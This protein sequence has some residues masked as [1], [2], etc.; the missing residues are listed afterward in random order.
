MHDSKTI[1]LC[2]SHA[3]FVQ[4]G[5]VETR[6]LAWCNAVGADGFASV[7]TAVQRPARALVKAAFSTVDASTLACTVLATTSCSAVIPGAEGGAAVPPARL[8]AVWPRTLL[9]AVVADTCNTTIFAS[10]FFRTAQA[11]TIN[12][13]VF[14]RA[15][16]R[17]LLAGTI[18]STEFAG[19]SFRTILA[20][21]PA[22]AA[23]VAI[24]EFG[25]QFVIET[26]GENIYM[27][28]KTCSGVHFAPPQR[29]R[30]F[31]GPR[32]VPRAC[33]GA[34]I[35]TA[36]DPAGLASACFSAIVTAA[37]VSA[38]KPRAG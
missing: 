14:A 27:E 8:S 38:F 15:F 10:T 33:N 1:L 17:A 20:G 11:T 28:K 12:P 22:P 26:S 19:A 30:R 2:D 31:R 36:H 13:T 24:A 9:A 34:I 4:R 21:A 6:E 7:Y 37:L 29:R 5:V 25:V 3:P 32:G 18:V 35:A 16:S 23:T